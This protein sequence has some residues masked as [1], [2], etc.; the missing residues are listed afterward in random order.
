[1]V[2]ASDWLVGDPGAAE[3]LPHPATTVAVQS[4][5]A[6]SAGSCARRFNPVSVARG[7]P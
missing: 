1:M 4:T 3:T 6:T 7:A 2:V 5:C